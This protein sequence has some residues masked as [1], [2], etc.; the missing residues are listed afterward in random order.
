MCVFLCAFSC[1][2]CYV[3]EEINREDSEVFI[4]K[5]PPRS[6][7][8]VVMVTRSRSELHYI[9]PYYSTR[10]R[11]PFK[12]PHANLL[13]CVILAAKLHITFTNTAIDITEV[14]IEYFS[15]TL[16]KILAGCH[17]N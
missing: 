12:V 9:K 11:L 4:I 6:H 15:D 8:E 13:S 10:K 2:Q 3:K 14:T 16:F 1:V 7:N 5:I 17:K